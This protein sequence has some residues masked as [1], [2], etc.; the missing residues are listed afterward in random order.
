LTGTTGGAINVAGRKISPAKVEAAIMATG[1]ALRVK[2]LGIPSR[3][4]ERFEEIAAVVETRDGITPATLKSAVAER[5]QL[6][7][8]PRHWKFGRE[9]WNL[10]TAELRRLFQKT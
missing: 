5:L 10:D 8:I 4:P 9:D 6:W 2:V 7:E 1:L 3:D